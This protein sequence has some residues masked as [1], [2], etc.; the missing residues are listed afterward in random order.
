[1][2]RQCRVRVRN[3]LERGGTGRD[4]AGYR[5]QVVP[6]GYEVRARFRWEFRTVRSGFDSRRLHPEKPGFPVRFLSS[7]APGDDGWHI[8]ASFGT[9]EPDRLLADRSSS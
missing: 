7:E 8:D 1:M 3:G 9:R 6:G 4:A 5:F 2:L